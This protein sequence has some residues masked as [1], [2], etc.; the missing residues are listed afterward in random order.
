[1]AEDHVSKKM[2]LSHEVQSSVVYDNIRYEEFSRTGMSNN[3]SAGSHEIR[4]LERREHQLSVGC[5][6][7]GGR[8]DKR[9]KIIIMGYSTPKLAP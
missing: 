8:G 5:R 9:T 6:K 1:M 2:L 3:T 4:A 7:T